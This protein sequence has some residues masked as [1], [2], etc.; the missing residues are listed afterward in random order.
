MPR[1]TTT[2]TNTTN[3]NKK[4]KK[5]QKKA[6]KD[7]SEDNQSDNDN[8]NLRSDDDGSKQLSNNETTQLEVT[9]SSKWGEMNHSEH[10][11]CDNQS[12]GNRNNHVN[13]DEDVNDDEHVVEAE[14]NQTHVL[15]ESNESHNLDQSKQKKTAKSIL[16]F[17]RE[18][19]N[20]SET[21]L[22]DASIEDLLKTIIS[23]SEKNGHHRLLSCAK[24]T[25][26]AMNFECDFPSSE[27]E[28]RFKSNNNKFNATKDSHFNDRNTNLDNKYDKYNKYNKNNR[29]NTLVKHDDTMDQQYPETN[30]NMNNDD[31]LSHSYGG[32][33]YGNSTYGNNTHG[34]STYGNSTYGNNGNNGNSTYGGV[35][36]YTR[37]QKSFRKPNRS[38]NRGYIRR[39]NITSNE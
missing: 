19:Y 18:K 10:S 27:K 13:D 21:P 32:A 38:E 36:K 29:N 37:E 4:P 1:Q 17:D 23:K 35:S 25:L 2:T 26:K 16:N 31:V 14:K 6:K 11:D 15:V 34:N 20:N 5:E 30:S 12:D 28:N 33:T 24:Q 39:G 7:T 3:K 9:K 8:I 22:K